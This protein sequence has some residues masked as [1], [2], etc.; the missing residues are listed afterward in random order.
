MAKAADPPCQAEACE[1]QTCLNKN[2]YKPE[3]CEEHMRNLYK[4]C[5][6]MYEQTDGKGEST[7]CPMP[8]AVQRWLKNHGGTAS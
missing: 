6:A 2:T 4:C 8:S 1:L 5:Q 7:A 3:K